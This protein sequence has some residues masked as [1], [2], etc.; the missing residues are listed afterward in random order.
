MNRASRLVRMR[1]CRLRRRRRS[2]AGLTLLETL[3]YGLCLSVL[4][5]LATVTLLAAQRSF[6]ETRAA[7]AESA[8]WERMAGHVRRDVH[9][10]QQAQVAGDTLHLQTES[11]SV[12]YRIADRRLHREVDVAAQPLTTDHAALPRGRRLAWQIAERGEGLTEHAQFVE[13]RLQDDTGRVVWRLLAATGRD[14]RR[15]WEGP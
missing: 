7:V 12:T 6:F 5:S 2:R 11:R 8:A 9:R 13:L 15:G 1:P 4:S 14:V 3:T 10:A